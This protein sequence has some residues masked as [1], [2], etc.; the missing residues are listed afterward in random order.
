M[1]GIALG[2]VAPQNHIYERKILH[3]KNETVQCMLSLYN[4]SDYCNLH[5][6]CLRGQDISIITQLEKNIKV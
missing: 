5:W 1:P 6:L 3:I 2:A 4:Q